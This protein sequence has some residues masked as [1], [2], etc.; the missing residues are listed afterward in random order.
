MDIKWHP[1]VSVTILTFCPCAE[2]MCTFLRK[3]TDVSNSLP[4]SS[5]KFL[6]APHLNAL[7]MQ[8]IRAE[9]PQQKIPLDKGRNP[10]ELLMPCN[11]QMLLETKY[12]LLPL[13]T[14][15]SLGVTSSL[16]HW[17]P[18]GGLSLPSIR[19]GHMYSGHCTPRPFLELMAV[20]PNSCGFEDSR[21]SNRLN[22]QVLQA[23]VCLSHNVINSQT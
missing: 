6:L 10:Q 22:S 12:W 4:A 8:D 7:Y 15:C 20:W 21:I 19:H 2:S 18:L 23:S 1:R 3:R 17:A 14:G 13:L 9:Q 5:F 11:V 16:V